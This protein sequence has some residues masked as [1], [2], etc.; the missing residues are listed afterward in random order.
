MDPRSHGTHVDVSQLDTLR[1][2]GWPGNG[3]SQLGVL[4]RESS[5]L[6][7]GYATK[8]HLESRVVFV[9]SFDWSCVSFGF[10]VKSS[11]LSLN[12]KA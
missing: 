11:F 1:E 5:I 10:V 12:K 3:V 7:E 9:E 8:V 4:V 2:D 6:I